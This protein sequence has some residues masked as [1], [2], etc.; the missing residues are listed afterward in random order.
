MTTDISMTTTS[1]FIHSEFCIT[2]SQGLVPFSTFLDCTR[3]NEEEK[4]FYDSFGG[5][6]EVL[7]IR[8]SI[9]LSQLVE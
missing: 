6:G 7:L 8:G 1:I 9:F 2:F 5:F 4:L 3:V